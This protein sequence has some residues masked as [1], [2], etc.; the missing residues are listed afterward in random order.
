[1]VVITICSWEHPLANEHVILE[2]DFENLCREK[3]YTITDIS[4]HHNFPQETI[5]DLK[6]NP[7]PVSLSIRLTPDLI[8]SKD[9]D[10]KFYELKTGNFEDVIKVEAYQ[11]MLNQIRENCF[12]TECIYVYRGTLTN[13]DIIACHAKDIVPSALIVP[14]NDK[15]KYIEPILEGYFQCK[16][17][18]KKMGSL[19]SGDAYIEVKDLKKWEPID[20]FIK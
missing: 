3:G 8:V 16:K 11:L 2:K 12:C 10:T 17:Q 13:G 15:N 20:S 19:Y 18:R 4:Y 5:R 9:D 14:Y 6:N 7:S 1:M